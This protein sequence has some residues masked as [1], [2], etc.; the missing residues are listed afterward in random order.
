[1]DCSIVEHK[2]K[3]ILIVRTCHEHVNYNSVETIIIR[4]KIKIPLKIYRKN[5]V[6][7]YVFK[8]DNRLIYSN[9]KATQQHK[10]DSAERKFATFMCR[11]DGNNTHILL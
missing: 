4:L 10:I 5:T 3:R 9:I 11:L 6:N 2:S 8:F 7:V 1:M